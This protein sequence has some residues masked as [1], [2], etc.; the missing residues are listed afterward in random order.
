MSNCF[1]AAHEVADLI[2]TE[3]GPKQNT[4]RNI[5]LPIMAF[6]PGDCKTMQ[7]TDDSLLT[8]LSASGED[9]SW[10]ARALDRQFS[11]KKSWQS[12]GRGPRR[13]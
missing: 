8:N 11:A 6:N 3:H 12:Q 7:F 5:S 13:P 10:R 4:I 2:N 9:D 1:L